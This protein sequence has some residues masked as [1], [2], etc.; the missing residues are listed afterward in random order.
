M[1]GYQIFRNCKEATT[2]QEMKNLTHI[3]NHLRQKS[4]QGLRYVHTDMATVQIIVIRDE[5]LVNFTKL[6][7][8]LGYLI[9]LQEFY[10]VKN[11]I[12]LSSRL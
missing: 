9:M 12:Q 2:G 8:Q 7:I 3:I 6:K 11:I 5:K 4:D 1:R 10:G